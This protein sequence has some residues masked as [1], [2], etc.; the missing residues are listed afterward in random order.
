[1][2]PNRV[3]AALLV[4]TVLLGACRSS[5]D[6]SPDPA[7][8]MRSLLLVMTDGANGDWPV[9]V[10]LVRVRDAN[11][12]TELLRIE[13]AAWFRD[14]GEKFAKANP[15]A[16]IEQWEIVPGT[17][18]GPLNVRVRA[19]VTGVVF[20]NIPGTPPVRLGYHGHVTLGIDDDGC[21]L[22]GDDPAD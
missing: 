10:D 2:T 1:M 4:A 17:S 7:I 11:L 12:L 8:R 21:T 5:N 3:A 9:A 20:C 15:D 22:R 14:A 19:K 13:S 16:L 18:V 6:A